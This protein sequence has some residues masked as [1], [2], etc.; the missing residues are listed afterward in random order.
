MDTLSQ[1]EILEQIRQL[2]SNLSKDDRLELLRS[3]TALLAEL[4]AAMEE[5][6]AS[7]GK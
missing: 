5:Y 1:G 6:I 3:L 4:N 2:D 7:A